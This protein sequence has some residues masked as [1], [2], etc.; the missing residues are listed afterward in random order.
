M[1]YYDSLYIPMLFT[2]ALQS[3][4]V[5]EE[6]ADSANVSISSVTLSSTSI[7]RKTLNFRK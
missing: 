2:Q 4:L 3:S 6:N 5:I 7:A 1:Y